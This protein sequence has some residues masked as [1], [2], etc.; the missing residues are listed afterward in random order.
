MRNRNK[1]FSKVIIV[2]LLVAVALF[3]A[4]MIVIFCFKDS[5]PD[6]LVA[7]FFA[8]CGGEAGILGFIKRGETKNESKEI[9]AEG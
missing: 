3:T 5:V 7:A 9:N 2:S 6:S 1:K 4:T 8:F